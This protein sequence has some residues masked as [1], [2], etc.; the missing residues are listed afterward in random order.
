MPTAY[1]DDLRRK[2]LEA[3]RREEGSLSQLAR[4]FCVSP[5][6]A[7]KISSQLHRTGKMERAAGRR[8]GP[9]SK[10]TAE[11][12][13]DLKDWIARQADLTLAELQ[14][15]LFEQRRLEISMSRLWTVLKGLGL[16]LKKS[17]STPPSKTPKRGAA[18][19]RTGAKRAS[20]STRRT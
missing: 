11:I 12:Q 3:H 2:L 7:L 5:G 16:R 20:R 8:R 17:R 15:R 10:I 19:A 4:R 1:S 13:Q 6:W 9:A 18:G 14:L